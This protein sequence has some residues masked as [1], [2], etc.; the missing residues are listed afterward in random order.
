MDKDSLYEASLKKV[1]VTVLVLVRLGQWL[2]LE[3]P[4]GRRKDY[5]TVIANKSSVEK[6]KK[7]CAEEWFFLVIFRTVATKKIWRNWEVFFKMVWIL[8]KNAHEMEKINKVYKPQNWKKKERK[9]KTGT[10]V[11][12]CAP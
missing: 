1:S 8:E 7:F 6:Q 10:D 5:T 12:M 2:W 9:R 3:H 11:Y 4:G